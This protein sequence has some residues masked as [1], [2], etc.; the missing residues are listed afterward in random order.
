MQHLKDTQL[1]IITNIGSH[2]RKPIFRLIDEQICGDF[3]IGDHTE[4]PIKT[5]NYDELTG[6]KG[7][8]HN[9][10]FH[11]F[12]WQKGSVRLVFKKYEYYILTG[13]PYC[14]SSWV[15][16]LI[17]KLLGKQTI[18]WSHGFYGR[19]GWIK[20]NIKKIYYS[21]FSKLM[22]YN[23]YAIDL[24]TKEGFDRKKMFCIA[25][26]MDSDHELEIR[27]R[28]KETDIYSSH[29]H[30]NFPTVI[31]CGR[32]QKIKKLDQLI[33]AVKLLQEQDFY[34]NIVIVG[35]DS[36]GVEIDKYAESKGLGKQ[37]W[38]YGPCYDDNLL[39]EL[40][41][42][43][44]ACVSPGNIGLTAIHSLTFGC[45][46]ITHNNFKYQMPEFEAISPGKTGEFFNQNDIND[47]A[48]KI[49][50]WCSISQQSRERARQEAFV[51][52]DSKWNIHYQINTL[53]KVCGEN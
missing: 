38:M 16:L 44:S 20:K 4:K 41:Y 15:I 50:H 8:L 3:Y 10:F 12:Y 40:F 37:L 53:K 2:Y 42:N 25:N 19:E 47:L 29:F 30:N 51:S 45:P 23:E 5:F 39:G 49:K 22:I 33:D 7:I 52:I 48:G 36:E 27:R 46:A 11:H 43:A 21:L 28:L 14:L 35:K 9:V 26:S 13:E 17:A 24:M 1:C 32:I 6:Y 34:V 31:Y 18:S